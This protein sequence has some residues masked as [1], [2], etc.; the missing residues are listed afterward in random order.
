MITLTNDV[1]DDVYN[2]F[3]VHDAEEVMENFA[4][5]AYCT[6]TSSKAW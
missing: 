5:G 4:M 1:I 2:S 3:D 6:R